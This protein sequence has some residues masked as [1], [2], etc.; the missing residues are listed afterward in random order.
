VQIRTSDDVLK[1]IEVLTVFDRRC[2]DADA[3]AFAMLMRRLKEVDTHRTVI[4]VQVENESG[5]L[6]DARDRSP[7]A[8]AVFRAPVP[9][10]LAQ[11]LADKWKSPNIAFTPNH[12]SFDPG[13]MGDAG[14]WDQCFGESAQTDELFMAYHYAL[15]LDKIAAAG[16][17]EY[18]LPLYINAWLPKPDDTPQTEG[19]AAGGHKPGIYPSG[20]A[21]SNVLHIWKMFAPSVDFISPDIYTTDYTETCAIYAGP[22]KP[23]FIPEQR[24][25]AFGARRICQAIGSFGAIG[26]S[27][28]AVDT[29]QEEDCAFAPLYKLLQSVSGA[30]LAAQTNPDSIW[31]FF[32]DDFALNTPDPSPSFKKQFGEYELKVSRA[33][34]LGHPGPGT[35]IILHRGPGNFMIIGM[36]FKVQ[37][38]SLSPTSQFTGILTCTEKS[39]LDAYQGTFKTLRKLNG[40]ETKGGSWCNM[41][42]ETPDYG[43]QFIPMCIPAGTMITEVQVYSLQ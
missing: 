41:P 32:F 11:F 37:F 21:T 5:I 39:V 19:L 40:D 43:D 29:L 4:M 25:D 17:R 15:Y 7:A 36:G 28:F 27:P 16:K 12:T 33:F 26:V 20:G 14:D 8:E 6:G 23:F 1:T 30:I 42:N 9:Q 2:V 22:D 10:Q 18:P 34:V 38:D 3:K 24:R 13:L 31:G 35:G